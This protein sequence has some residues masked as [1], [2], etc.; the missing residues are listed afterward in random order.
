M[1]ISTGDPGTTH[2]RFVTTTVEVEGR[3]E[4]KVVELPEHEPEPWGE[5]ADLSIVGRRA[6]RVD[7]PDKVSGRARYTSDLTRPGL[8]H[9]AILRSTIARGKVTLDLEPAR[10]V[11]GVVDVIGS[12]ELERRIR[13][14]SGALFDTTISFAGQALAAVC[15]ETI[16]AAWRGVQAIAARRIVRRGRLQGRAD[17]APF[18][19]GRRRRLT[20][21]E[22]ASR[23]AGHRRAGRRRARA[24]RGRRH[25]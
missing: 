1:A 13:L 23:L 15:A 20:V 22:S 10:K 11:P 16:D 12:A 21:A 14:T 6:Q 17:G 2:R 18:E 9:A 24:R 3:D 25:R 4:T 8:L 19:Q 7:A 5:D